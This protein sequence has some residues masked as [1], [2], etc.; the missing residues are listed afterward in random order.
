M[1]YTESD[2]IKTDTPFDYV[3]SIATSI[4][5]A[6][7]RMIKEISCKV[8]Y[9]SKVSI[10]RL[11]C[12]ATLICTVFT[13]SYAIHVIKLHQ[14]NLTSGKFPIFFRLV[15]LVVLIALSILY[16]LK[17][18]VPNGIKYNEVLKIQSRH[19]ESEQAT[20]T[21]TNLEK[22]AVRQSKVSITK[23]HG[24]NQ[25]KIAREEKEGS[26]TKADSVILNDEVLNIETAK[27]SDPYYNL[28]EKVRTPQEYTGTFK[29]SELEAIDQYLSSIPAN[30]K[31]VP[32]EDILLSEDICFDDVL[33]N[34]SLNEIM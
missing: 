23:S 10:M 5:L 1:R 9:L 14:F 21:M 28:S 13:L 16:Y 22:Q 15:A 17:I 25:N 2:K 12:V 8:A 27:A 24:T 6:P 34:L 26:N 33:S 20:D 19:K 11:L 30:S 29:G 32:T 31:I 4:L 18:A 3:I 7:F